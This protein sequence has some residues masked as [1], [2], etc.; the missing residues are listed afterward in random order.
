M[1]PIRKRLDGK[2]GSRLLASRVSNVSGAI[3]HGRLGFLESGGLT[4][5]LSAFSAANG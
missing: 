1:D 4:S 3:P 5:G 2:R